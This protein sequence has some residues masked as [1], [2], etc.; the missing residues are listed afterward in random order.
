MSK[1]RTDGED[2]AVGCL[3]VLGMILAAWTAM[4]GIVIFL[5]WI[6]QG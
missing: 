1:V 5:I 4:I 2:V 6:V 3:K